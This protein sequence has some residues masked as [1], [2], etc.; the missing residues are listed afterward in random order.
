VQLVY[1]FVG[2]LL[3]ILLMIRPATEIA[4]AMQAPTAGDGRP[5][6]S[7]SF[8]VARI[9]AAANASRSLGPG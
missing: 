3:S 4:F 8:L 9:L 6:Q 5:F 2:H 1:C 7:A